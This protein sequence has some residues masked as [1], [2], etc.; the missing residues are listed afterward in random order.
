MLFLGVELG[1]VLQECGEIR[2]PPLLS[3]LGQIGGIV[4]AFA[5][6]GV[7]V[8]A[9]AVMPDIFSPDDLGRQLVFIGKPGKTLVTVECKANEGD[10]GNKGANDKKKAVPVAWSFRYLFEMLETSTAAAEL[11]H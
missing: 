5:Q 6:E 1:R 2:R 7:A 4:A 11:I 3:N 8:D 9:V 10:G